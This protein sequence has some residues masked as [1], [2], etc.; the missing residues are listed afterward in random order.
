MS[1]NQLIATIISVFSTIIF[2][3][4][5]DEW[6]QGVI[7]GLSIASIC[8]IIELRILLESNTKK[9]DA[10]I[11]NSSGQIL[12]ILRN[13]QL[14]IL[15][16]EQ[17]LSASIVD[18]VNN[19]SDRLAELIKLNNQYFHE[20][21]LFTMLERIVEARKLAIKRTD[22]TLAF[23]KIIY[24]A[25]DQIERELINGFRV[26]TGED[27]WERS[28]QL[29][30]IVSGA[31][32]YV[33]ALTFDSN[34]YLNDFW[35]KVFAKEYVETNLEAAR[36][37]VKVERIF[38]VDSKIISG[39]KLSAEEQV[40]RERL[41]EISKSLSASNNQ[42]KVYWVSKQ[43]LPDELKQTNTSFL[44]S[45]DLNASESNGMDRNKIISSYVVY[46][47]PDIVDNLKKRFFSLRAYA[48]EITPD[49]I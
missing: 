25:I 1:Q 36:R 11:K 48:K 40:T 37:G 19:H 21:E 41:I 16:S 26:E 49:E 17:D 42:S 46:R 28:K 18:L 14:E 29:K 31:K 15:E 32:L 24:N 5:F 8:A 7:A 44:V 38:I 12:D 13:N 2:A 6:K 9:I 39:D 4:L 3:L 35:A 27:E 34:E 47:K 33:Y 43:S 45:D 22:N 20:D 10:A 23:H 30:E